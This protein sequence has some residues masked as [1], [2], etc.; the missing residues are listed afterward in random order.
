[1]I[2]SLNARE[3][4]RNHMAQATGITTMPTIGTTTSRLGEG[5]KH[6][7]LYVHNV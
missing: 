1:M 5:S 2:A 7:R 3:G 4:L 6:V